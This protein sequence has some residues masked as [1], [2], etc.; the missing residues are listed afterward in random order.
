[1]PFLSLSTADS[2]Q[3]LVL[4]ILTVTLIYTV[5]KD[6]FI[7]YSRRKCM[8]ILQ[9]SFCHYPESKHYPDDHSEY[10]RLDVQVINTGQKEIDIRTILVET[11]TKNNAELH[12]EIEAGSSRLNTGEARRYH[13]SWSKQ[14]I[15]EKNVLRIVFTDYAGKRYVFNAEKYLKSH[16]HS[17]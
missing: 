6:I 2:I 8:R 10:S 3:L 1:M 16:K 14:K 12:L 5:S 4:I 11:R 7:A 15:E 9:A 17:S 13:L